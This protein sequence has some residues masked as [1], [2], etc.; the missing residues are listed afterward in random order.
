MS[1]DIQNYFNK[2]VIEHLY[3]DEIY[4]SVMSLFS[5][6]IQKK[7]YSK[8]TQHIYCNTKVSCDHSP[9]AGHLL[10]VTMSSRQEEVTGLRGIRTSRRNCN[11]DLRYLYLQ[12]K[13][14]P[15][16][17]GDAMECKCRCTI[18]TLIL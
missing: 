11:T 6:F 16:S 18:Q 1:L 9:L 7:F 14:P 10:Q 12:I 4:I 8:H 3:M 15:F 2:I 5:L 17:S 13:N